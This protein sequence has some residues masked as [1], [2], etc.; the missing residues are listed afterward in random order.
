MKNKIL[1]QLL[2]E[3]VEELWYFP[4]NIS[5]QEIKTFFKIF[6]EDTFGHNCCDFEEFM[7]NYYSEIECERIFAEEVYV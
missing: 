2:G 1:Y 6:E 5:I 7:S 4:E 3:N